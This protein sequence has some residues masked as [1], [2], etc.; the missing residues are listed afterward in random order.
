MRRTQEWHRQEQLEGQLL[1]IYQKVETK[2]GRRQEEVRR[3]ASEARLRNNTLTEKL[4]EWK[5]G[6]Q[7][8]EEL[9]Y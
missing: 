2:Q 1:E 5:R 6:R 7:E 9:T 8:Q 4:H 3:V